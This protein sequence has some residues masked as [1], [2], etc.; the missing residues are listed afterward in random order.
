MEG[1]YT[2]TIDATAIVDRA[3][4][5]GNT[6]KS[7]SW[8]IDLSPPKLLTNLQWESEAGTPIG[9]KTNLT[10]AFIVGSLDEPSRIVLSQ[11][12]DGE[13]LLVQNI[14][15]GGFRIPVDLTF[16]GLYELEISFF[17]LAGNRTRIV[18][19]S[20]TVDR[21]STFVLN[22]INQANQPLNFI[23]SDPIIQLSRSITPLNFDSSK[24][25]VY[26]NGELRPPTT[27]F[28]LA[29]ITDTPVADYRLLGLSSA[30]VSDGLWKIVVSADAL[31][32][33]ENEFVYEFTLDR[34]SPQLHNVSFSTLVSP[35]STAVW[36]VS[37]TGFVNLPE[38]H[39]QRT[40]QF[41]VKLQQ[42]SH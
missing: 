42:P 16:A 41:V 23:P 30:I 24:V 34:V 17:D 25:L 33:I 18:A 14:P 29:P 1:Q 4:N 31:P 10:R 2:F 38:L 26:R 40:G 36:K 6:N 15:A 19:P 32:G 8:K 5:R 28:S 35:V 20:I 11:R 9:A 22:P 21:I 13:R 39:S 12:D 37:F 7:L 27:S 3:G